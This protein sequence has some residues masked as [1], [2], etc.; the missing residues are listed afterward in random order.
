MLFC[1]LLALGD[2]A[3]EE[4]PNYLYK[5]LSPAAW[6]ESQAGDKLALGPDDETFIHL[7]EDHQVERIS[8][9]FFSEHQKVVVIKLRVAD[10]PGRLVKESNPGGTT[11][12]YH[13]YDGYLP[14]QA[15]ESHE[16]VDN[17]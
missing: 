17:S 10:L 3:P 4:A 5:I 14:L 9:K 13:L 2:P 7:A 6:E 1:V 8:R 11:E 15:V 16:L 12:Y